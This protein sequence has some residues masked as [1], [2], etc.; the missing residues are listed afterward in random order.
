MLN[1][2]KVHLLAT[3]V[4]AAFLLLA[5]ACTTTQ[6]VGLIGGEAVTGGSGNQSLTVLDPQDPALGAQLSVA[7]HYALAIDNIANRA[8]A[9]DRRGTIHSIDSLDEAPA[10]SSSPLAMSH[11][12]AALAVRYPLLIVAIGTRQ[13]RSEGVVSTSVLTNSDV[14]EVS[15]G[16]NVPYA[17]EVCDD[18]ETVLVGLSTTVR[19]FTVDDSG[20]L[21]DTGASFNAQNPLSNVYCAPGSNTAVVV[22]SVTAN[23][24][25]LDTATMD[26]VDVRG[27]AARSSTAR[28]GQPI[29]LSGVFAPDG[30]RF[31]VRSERGDVTGDGFVESFSFTPGTGALGSN[32]NR[33]EVEPLGFT[34]RG[35]HHLA[36]SLNGER[37]FVT[38]PG[39]GRVRV[40]DA[41]SLTQ[42]D[43][44]TGPDFET[45]L[46]I[47][48]GG[49]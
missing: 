11:T 42:T 7:E 19:K 14:D 34:S 4:S 37:L 26:E 3:T 33:V 32:P 10:V 2:L 8:Y 39:Q 27:L 17:V 1:V 25:S 6:E 9:S 12:A 5:S 22:S 21:T 36:L 46:T 47:V 35:V 16:S 20:S 28:P 43:T 48:I 23:L 44:L 13:Q 38:E 24:R 49:K 29:G 45:P 18:N 15:L 40:F 41:L 31:Y 30:Q